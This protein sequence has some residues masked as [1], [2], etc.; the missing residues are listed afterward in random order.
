MAEKELCKGVKYQ[1][2][3]KEGNRTANYILGL[4][5]EFKPGKY[6]K[7]KTNK[8]SR[9]IPWHNIILIDD[10]DEEFREGEI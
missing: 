9:I 1:I 5:E 2:I 3:T 6:I 10:T 8:R 7:I 4:L